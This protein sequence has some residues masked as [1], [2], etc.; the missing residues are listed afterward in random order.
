MAELISRLPKEFDN[1]KIKLSLGKT[2]A[3]RIDFEVFCLILSV[4]RPNLVFNYINLNGDSLKKNLLNYISSEFLLKR[5][6]NL[7]VSE[8][9]ISSI[10]EQ[11]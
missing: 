7:L 9:I 10:D 2:E 6:E 8:I 11:L 5:V 1:K 3:T 4:K